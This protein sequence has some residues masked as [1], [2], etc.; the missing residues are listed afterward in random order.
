MRKT[1]LIYIIRKYG[2]GSSRLSLKC[3]IK[4]EDALKK[5]KSYESAELRIVD[6]IDNHFEP[7][8]S[9]SH[10]C[11]IESCGQAIRY[12][13]VLENKVTGQRIVAGST[14]VWPLLG[15]SEI[16]K[17]EFLTMEEVIRERHLVVEWRQSH[18]EVLERLQVMRANQFWQFRPFW[19]E[20]EYTRLTDDDTNYILSVDLERLVNEKRE[21]ERKQEERRAAEEKARLEAEEAE[22]KLLKGLDKLVVTYPQNTFYASLKR[23]VDS[24]HKLSENQIRHVKLGCNRLWYKECI[25]GTSRDIM[26]QCVEIMDTVKGQLGIKDYDTL[27]NEEVKRIEV[28]IQA[29]DERIKLAWALLRVK[30]D[31]VSV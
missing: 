30:K 29:F 2:L 8:R 24:G 7:S 27:S 17:K 9:I 12:E 14:C 22:Q 18:R 6:V 19:E 28:D 16:Q 11:Q 15:F 4:Y 26:D 31:I 1:P 25:K 10:H 3:R 20:V 23:Q 21:K 13:Y 5:M